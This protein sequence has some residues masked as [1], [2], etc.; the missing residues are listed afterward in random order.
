MSAYDSYD[1][2]KNCRVLSE[3]LN[4]FVVGEVQSSRGA[5]GICSIEGWAMV[6][7]YCTR[8]SGSIR[9][10][11]GAGVGPAV[12]LG[13]C[14]GRGGATVGCTERRACTCISLMRCYC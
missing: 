2:K 8:C 5:G 6:T 11:S 1:Y 9:L 14:S 10:M 13:R 7:L 3:V 12:G 4:R